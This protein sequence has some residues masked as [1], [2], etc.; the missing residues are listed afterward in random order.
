MHIV[1]IPKRESTEMYRV[2]P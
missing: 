2:V 1:E